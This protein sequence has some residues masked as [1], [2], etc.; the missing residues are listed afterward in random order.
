M[1]V[2]MSLLCMSR[3]FDGL[4]FWLQSYGPGLHPVRCLGSGGGHSHDSVPR[5]SPAERDL[6]GIRQTVLR[7][8]LALD[9]HG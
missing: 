3:I 7:Q 6:E 5:W 8:Q 1:C 2:L 9:A 4:V